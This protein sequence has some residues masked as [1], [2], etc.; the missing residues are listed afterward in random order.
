MLINTDTSP[1]RRRED[2]SFTVQPKSLEEKPTLCDRCVRNHICPIIDHSRYHEADSTS[3]ITHCKLFI[4]PFKFQSQQGLKEPVFNTLRLGE[5]WKKRLRAGDLIGLISADD[6][7]IITYARVTRVFSGDK[8]KM[9]Q[10]HAGRNHLTLKMTKKE[11][12]EYLTIQLPRIFGN[13][14]W[15]NNEKMTVIY[16]EPVGEGEIL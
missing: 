9:I 16:M 10:T 5:A 4:A 15:K 1:I 6:N 3:A 13:L 2:G 14:I 7:E 12:I 8:Q 11:A